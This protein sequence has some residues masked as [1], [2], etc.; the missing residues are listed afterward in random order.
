MPTEGY[1]NKAGKKMR[2]TKTLAVY[3]NSAGKK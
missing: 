2:T 1:H 3:F